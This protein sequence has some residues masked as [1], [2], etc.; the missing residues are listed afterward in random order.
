MK[1]EFIFHVYISIELIVKYKQSL[2]NIKI[3][4]IIIDF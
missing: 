4:L 3:K 1:G 2:K